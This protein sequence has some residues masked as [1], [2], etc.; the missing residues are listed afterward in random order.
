MHRQ[1][2]SSVGSSLDEYG[3][4]DVEVEIT[5][6]SSERSISSKGYTH[7]RR[8]PSPKRFEKHPLVRFLT[9]QGMLNIL[10]AIYITFTLHYYYSQRTLNPSGCIDVVTSASASELQYVHNQGRP[11]LLH[12]RKVQGGSIGGWHDPRTTV[13]TCTTHWAKGIDR[14]AADKLKKMRIFFSLNLRDNDGGERA[15]VYLHA[16]S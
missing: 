16:R 5:R 1:P 4:T 7:A 9:G 8:T 15:L 3:R 12:S 13:A 14:V 10:L 6:C 2:M 11:V